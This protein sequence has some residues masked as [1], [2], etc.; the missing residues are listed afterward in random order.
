M[1]KT[2]KPQLV[3]V[4]SAFPATC[5][6]THR[7]SGGLDVTVMELTDKGTPQ[8]PSF[9]N[10]VSQDS[11]FSGFEFSVWRYTAYNGKDEF[12]SMTSGPSTHSDSPLEYMHAAKGLSTLAKRQEAQYKARGSASDVPER[13]GR[14]LEA[15]G[16]DLVL[17]RPNGQ[18]HSWLNEG[19]WLQWSTG[20][21]VD[22]VRHTIESWFANQVAVNS[23]T[24]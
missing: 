11:L 20:Q 21:T 19:Q 16:I 3:A 22:I 7:D 12:H 24:A 2:S 18:H 1:K 15:M 5:L 17:T 4:L 14:W 13:L 8:N 9:H 10:D 6:F 23:A